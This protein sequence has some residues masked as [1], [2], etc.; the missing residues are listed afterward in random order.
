MAG[1]SDGFT[2]NDTFPGQGWQG[3]FTFSYRPAMNGRVNEYR[4]SIKNVP[5][6]TTTI[7]QIEFLKEFLTSWDRVD[8]QGNPLSLTDDM[9]FQTLSDAAITYL[10]SAV[11]GW[12]SDSWSKQA[13]N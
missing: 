1:I 10:W 11:S 12:G 7:K 6:K 5:A 3:P 4:D 2:I 9:A 13:K 8:D